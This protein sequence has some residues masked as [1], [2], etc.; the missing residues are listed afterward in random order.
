MAT[1]DLQ[2]RCGNIDEF[3]GIAALL[4]GVAPESLMNGVDDSDDEAE[5]PSDTEAAPKP[6]RTRKAKAGQEPP[7]PTQN[8]DGSPIEPVR[9]PVAQPTPGGT[10]APPAESIPPNQGAAAV[11]V[12]TPAAGGEP[13]GEVTMQQLKDAMADLLKA[14]NSGFA[15]KTLEDATG[16]RSLSSGTPSIAEKAKDDPAIMRVALDALV[17]GKTA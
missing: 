16:C 6:K 10:E 1:F 17:A 7:A 14:K 11:D 2:I 4:C 13:A 3:K 5:Q 9:E 8:P 12:F 15:L